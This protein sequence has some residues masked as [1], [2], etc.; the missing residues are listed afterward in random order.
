[1]THTYSIVA[2][3]P[4]RKQ[5]GAAMQSHHFAACNGVVWIEPGVGAAA[6]QALSDPFYAHVCFDLMRL[7]TPVDKALG[8]AIDVDAEYA[9]RR[10]VGIVDCRGNTA[11]HTGEGCIPHAGHRT[12]AGYSCQANMMLRD[13]VWDAMGVAFERCEG[14]LVDRLLIALEAA[15]R[16]GG[17]IRG[18]QSAVLKVASA[19]PRRKPWDEYLSDFRVYDSTH[20]VDELKRL[21]A[22]Q[23]LN[24][25][26]IA[27]HNL[28]HRIDTKDEQ[29]V[30][31]VMKRFLDAVEHV[32][33]PDSRLEHRLSFALTL[34][35]KGR[36]DEG[37]DCFRAL[38]AIDPEW[39]EIARRYAA[40]DPQRFHAE[41]VEKIAD[42]VSYR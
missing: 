2:Y 22:Y 6:S 11:A 34:M 7:G 42:S 27:E 25:R 37:R 14:D 33:N 18:R 8:A 23:K 21:V 26:V 17:D 38:F 41:L 36:L 29:S 20:P 31:L 13:T 24:D 10:Q 9:R 28:L 1:M 5:L 35:T 15:E 4:V 32:P 39:K 40:S 12:G 3:D 16:E 19:E 30:Q